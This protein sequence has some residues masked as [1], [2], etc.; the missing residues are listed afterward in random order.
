MIG[1]LTININHIL[2][3]RRNAMI[4]SVALET[5]RI[6][7]VLSQSPEGFSFQH[8]IFAEYSTCSNCIHNNFFESVLLSANKSLIL[9]MILV[10]SHEP[11]L[12]RVNKI[13]VCHKFHHSEQ[14]LDVNCQK[15]YQDATL[16]LGYILPFYFTAKM[17]VFYP[18]VG[19]T[20]GKIIL[21]R[22]YCFFNQTKV[23]ICLILPWGV[24]CGKILTSSKH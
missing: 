11:D 23:V 22:F 21:L 1:F 2:H 3:Q 17:T 12:R 18:V 6:V 7:G 5:I 14:N 8:S 15:E 9:Q 13:L 10:E 19:K 24:G 4:L 16:T 20:S